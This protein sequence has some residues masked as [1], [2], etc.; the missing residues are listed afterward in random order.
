MIFKLT[1]TWLSISFMAGGYSATT[2]TIIHGVD[3]DGKN[4]HAKQ[5]GQSIL[6]GDDLSV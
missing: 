1:S 4:Q 5:T 2:A 3:T 6:T